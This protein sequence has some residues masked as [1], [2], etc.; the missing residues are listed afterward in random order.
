MAE[1]SFVKLTTDECHSTLLM[2]SQHCNGLVLSVSLENTYEIKKTY[3]N[4]APDTNMFK[5]CQKYT[6]I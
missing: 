3:E 2:I 5:V 6:T 1:L 4:V